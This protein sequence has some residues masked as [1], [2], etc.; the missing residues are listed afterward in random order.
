VGTRRARCRSPARARRSPRVTV[1]HYAGAERR[2]ATGA[3]LVYGPI[4]HHIV[5]ASPH[6]LAGRVV[7]ELVKEI[8]TNEPM[9]AGAA[10]GQ[11]S[12]GAGRGAGRRAAIKTRDGLPQRPPRPGRPSRQ[13]SVRRPSGGHLGNRRPD[14]SLARDRVDPTVQT[15][16][17]EVAQIPQS[18]PQ[19]RGT[20]VD[21]PELGWTIG[22]RNRTSA[23][24][25]WTA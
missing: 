24:L 22:P 16:G 7:L 8:S 5:A 18:I 13:A 12:T 1:D 3:R 10:Y 20:S 17:S 25:P 6:R 14:A 19:T 2:W 21:Q 15:V 9:E 4:A 23:A 11:C